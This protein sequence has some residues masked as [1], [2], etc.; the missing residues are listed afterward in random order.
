MDLVSPQEGMTPV[1][2]VSASCAVQIKCTR[3]V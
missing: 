2:L 3:R 1:K